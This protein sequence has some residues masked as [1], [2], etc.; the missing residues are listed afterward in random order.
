MIN[1]FFVIL[2]NLLLK[3]RNRVTDEQ[4]CNVLSQQMINV[5]SFQSIVDFRIVNQLDVIVR[6]TVFGDVRVDRIVTRFEN[7]EPVV[8]QRLKSTFFARPAVDGTGNDVPA[9]IPID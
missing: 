3:Q 7:S 5:C 9:T 4:M 8:D 1:L 2:V 6:R